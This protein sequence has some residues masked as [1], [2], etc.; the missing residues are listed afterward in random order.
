[1]KKKAQL[2]LSKEHTGAKAGSSEIRSDS[3]NCTARYQERQ[4]FCSPALSLAEAKSQ[5]RELL[6]L[7]NFCSVEHSLF[8][9]FTPRERTFQ[10]FLLLGTFV[11]QER[12]FQELLL[13]KFKKTT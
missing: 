13:Q 10:E 11:S 9:T 1:M 2:A 8:G 3:V 5:Q 4:T 7:C 6:L 12:M